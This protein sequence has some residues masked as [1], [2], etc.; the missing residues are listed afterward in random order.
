M[1]KQ[2]LTRLYI[3]AVLTQKTSIHLNKE[4]SHYLATVMRMKAGF[5]LLV[6]NGKDGEW[7]ARITGAD[8]RSVT[9]EITKQ[10]RQQTAEPDVWLVFAPIKK[11]R[12]DFIA[13]KATELGI[14]ALMPVMTSRTIVDRV[15][16]ERME[17]NA[18]EA[19]EQCERLNIPAVHTPEKLLAVLDT[20][21]QDRMI[22]FCDEDL[23]GTSA[24]ETLQDAHRRYP[25]RPWAIIIGPEGGF[26]DAERTRI[27]AL[28]GCVTVSLGP[29]IL[30]ADTAAMAAISLWQAAI[31]DWQ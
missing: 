21:P 29:R 23:S 30:R 11:A 3:D 14:S 24:I 2:T 9:L 10:T 13:Q 7:R 1:R 27:K 8:K 16:S 19:A 5:E 20:W 12:L 18:L 15:K 28:P 31:G 4:Q 22:M 17:A 26:D 6:F 25:H